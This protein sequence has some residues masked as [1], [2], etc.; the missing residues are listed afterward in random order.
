MLI[1]ALPDT[2]AIDRDSL[3]RA[4]RLDPQCTDADINTQ[5]LR[6][7]AVKNKQPLD[8]VEEGGPL[9]D[10]DLLREVFSQPN[11][12]DA[13]VNAAIE[14]LDRNINPGSFKT[15]S[16]S[17]SDPNLQFKSSDLRTDDETGEVIRRRMGISREAWDKSSR[18]SWNGL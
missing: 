8:S 5:L 18:Q 9:L 1:T 13:E 4:L 15:L 17:I 2:S 12:T 6:L 16:A 14:A 10:G 3:K 7:Q 11:A